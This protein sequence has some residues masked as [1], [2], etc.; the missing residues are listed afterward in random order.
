MKKLTQ[1]HKEIL[2]LMRKGQSNKEIAEAMG[3]KAYEVTRLA[4]L[5][6]R[7]GEIFRAKGNKYKLSTA[8]Y[9]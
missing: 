4:N 9:E 7:K 6:E 3:L 5:G 2:V 1:R 8:T